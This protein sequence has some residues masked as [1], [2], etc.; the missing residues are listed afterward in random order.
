M[1]LQKCYSDFEL[2]GV[3]ET[4]LNSRIY[5]TISSRLQVKFSFCTRHNY[6]LLNYVVFLRMCDMHDDRCYYCVDDRYTMCDRYDDRCTVVCD[7]WKKPRSQSVRTVSQRCH[8][9]LP[10]SVTFCPEHS[11][12]AKILNRLMHVCEDITVDAVYP[13][14][15]LSCVDRFLL[16][17]Y[18]G[19]VCSV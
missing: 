12:V 10:T 6:K 16:A 14:A 3:T 13:A 11:L 7:R 19:C 18:H 1:N 5:Q 17:I 9:L 4:I 8:F 15:T 2:Q